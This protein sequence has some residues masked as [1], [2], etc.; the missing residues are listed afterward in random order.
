VG[1]SSIEWTEETWNPTRGCSRVSPGCEHCYAESIAARFSDAGY[2]FHG[3]ALRGKRG[4][5][6]TRRLAL[7][8]EQ[9][10]PGNGK[11]DLPLRWRR[12]RRIFVN[13]MSDL[14]HESLS[15]EDIAAIWGVMAACPQHTFQVLTKRAHR[16]RQWFEWIAKRPTGLLGMRYAPKL[17]CAGFAQERTGRHWTVPD[18][19]VWPLPNVWLGVSVESQEYAEERIPQLLSVPAAV[20]FVSYEPALGPVTFGAFLDAHRNHSCELG[21]E[22]HNG[23]EQC[24]ACHDGRPA[25]RLDWVIVGGESGPKARAFDVEWARSVVSECRQTKVACFVKQLGRKP[26]HGAPGAQGPMPLTNKK[27]N[28]MTEWPKDLRVRQWPSARIAA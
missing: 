28:D 23:S 2:P 6:W 26:F 25:P 13:S 21:G 7:V 9:S 27:G 20:R 4:P 10:F 19:A 15:N 1:R 17:V 8:D 24:A 3:F 11:L 12:P 22:A 18:A 16:M 5:R 14:F